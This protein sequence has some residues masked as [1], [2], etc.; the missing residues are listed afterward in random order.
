VHSAEQ[1]LMALGYPTERSRHVRN[2]A[3]I[4]GAELAPL[5]VREDTEPPYTAV[6]LAGQQL[7]EDMLEHDFDLSRW[8]ARFSPS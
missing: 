5:R 1:A 2:R 8:E 6:L 3:A 7:W 4:T